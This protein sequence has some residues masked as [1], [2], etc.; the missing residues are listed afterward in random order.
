MLNQD[1]VDRWLEVYRDRLLEAF[2]ERL[3]F[4]GCQGSWAR[5]EGRPDSDIDAMAVLDRIESED[6]ATY[7]DIINGL[8][9]P[10][11]ACGIFWSVDELR[12]HEPR[13]EVV[14]HWYG[15]R[16]LHGSMDGK[17]EPPTDADLIA[18]IRLRMGNSIHAARHYL[19]FP[20]DIAGKV[21]NLHSEF[22]YAPVTLRWWLLLTTGV[23]HAK[24]ANLV[25]ALTEPLDKEVARIALEWEDLAE[26]RSARLRYYIELLERWARDMLERL[27]KDR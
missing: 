12:H 17:V 24:T 15:I 22:K 8:P 6:L 3:V 19:L 23:Y 13:C 1:I 25:A 20:H 26:D 16:V 9:H 10:D 18:E 5:G 7:R 11:H 2:G 27:P 21:H 14:H 4:A